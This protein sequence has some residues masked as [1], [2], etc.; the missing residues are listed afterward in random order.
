MR[1]N[2]EIYELGKMT[3]SGELGW[4]SDLIWVNNSFLMP[5]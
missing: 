3:F 4:N 5:F 2:V 1:E